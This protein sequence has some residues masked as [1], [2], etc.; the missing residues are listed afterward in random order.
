MGLMALRHI[1]YRARSL[2]LTTLFLGEPLGD[3]FSNTWCTFFAINWQLSGRGIMVVEIF[4]RP[5]LRERMWGFALAYSNRSVFIVICL[6]NLRVHVTITV[7]LFL[8]FNT[9][10]SIIF[11][12]TSTNNSYR[13]FYFH[14]IS[15][16]R[17]CAQSP[18]WGVML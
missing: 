10:I 16:T 2:L 15:S 8:T 11:Y 7:T 18:R 5:T 1:S 3:R 9:L 6:Y 12:S 14:N 13:N 4:S 17:T